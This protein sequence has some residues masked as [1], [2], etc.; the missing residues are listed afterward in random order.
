ML[1]VVATLVV[2]ACGSPGVRSERSSAPLEFHH[3]FAKLDVPLSG[4]H[5][6]PAVGGHWVF[7]YGGER[8]S[9]GGRAFADGAVYDIDTQEWWPV[10]DASFT[11]PLFGARSVWTG[12]EFVV[13]G[14][15][16]PELHID[17]ENVDFVQC[18]GTRMAAAAF[19]PVAGKWRPVEAP[20]IRDLTTSSDVVET[21]PIGAAGGSAV[22][23]IKS[24]DVSVGSK[25][26]AIGPGTTS[27]EIPPL[28][29]AQ[30]RCALGDELFAF[31]SGDTGVVPT[32]AGRIEP[33]NT[34]AYRDG[35][36][37]GAGGLGPSTNVTY[38]SIGGR[39]DCT[40]SAIGYVG[41][42]GTDG[43]GG[44]GGEV[45]WFDPAS[46]WRR[47]PDLAPVDGAPDALVAQSGDT[48]MVWIGDRISRL[49][50]DGWTAQSTAGYRALFP[51][52]FPTSRPR[53]LA[54]AGRYLVGR[55]LVDSPDH[56]VIAF[57]DPAALPPAA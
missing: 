39:V 31:G 3:G 8:F 47:L 27:R 10:P 46:G 38:G 24:P 6:E 15:P 7:V 25:L 40:P 19:D 2:S 11:A 56:P 34:W 21:I 30:L 37:V 32:P 23:S 16:C 5:V 57:V 45:D 33:T 42:A 52:L 14:T 53:T 1:P 4:R 12:R 49:G 28:P 50:A 41:L 54:A 35:G 29:V 20:D 55:P 48:P 18:G 36:W 9:D 44:R 26:V 13:L 17:E 43:L 51:Q 22:F